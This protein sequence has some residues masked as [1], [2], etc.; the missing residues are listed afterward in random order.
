MKEEE[1]SLRDVGCIP[2]NTSDMKCQ[3]SVCLASDGKGVS[4]FPSCFR[5]SSTFLSVY[6]VKECCWAS[7][8]GLAFIC[9]GLVVYSGKMC[10]MD[11]Y[12]LLYVLASF[13]PSSVSTNASSLLLKTT[14]EESNVSGHICVLR[15]PGSQMPA[16]PLPSSSSAQNHPSL[17]LVFQNS[18]I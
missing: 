1:Q 2:M 13:H 15:T 11:F 12:S 4:P 6:D 17:C 9:C 3:C 10:C 7:F 8:G 14:V 18:L 5:V 16:L